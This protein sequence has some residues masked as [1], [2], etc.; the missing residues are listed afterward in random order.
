MN[1]GSTSQI[2]GSAI[3]LNY[4]QALSITPID[5]TRRVSAKLRHKGRRPARGRLR[6]HP[7]DDLLLKEGIPDPNPIEK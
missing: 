1:N 7:E 2:L 5:S 4:L 6:G 3:H